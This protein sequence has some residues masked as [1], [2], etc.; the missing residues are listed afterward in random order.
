MGRVKPCAACSV[1]TAALIKF[2]KDATEDTANM[3]QDCHCLVCC[4]CCCCCC[5]LIAIVNLHYVR[6]ILRCSIKVRCNRSW[7]LSS[8]QSGDWGTLNA[9]VAFNYIRH[10]LNWDQSKS[11]ER[12]VPFNYEYCAHS[13]HSS[14]GWVSVFYDDPLWS[15][16]RFQ[17]VSIIDFNFGRQLFFVAF[18][19]DCLFI[20]SRLHMVKL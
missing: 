4:C 19:L 18:S 11:E 15:K 2:D 14:S 8:T 5:R 17:L 20:F 9:R 7:G 6:I 1:A 12:R 10:R 13:A 3:G 16:S